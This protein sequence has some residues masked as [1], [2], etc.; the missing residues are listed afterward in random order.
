MCNPSDAI[1]YYC[2][3][4]SWLALFIFV[5]RVG[6]TENNK[7]I[8]ID[9]VVVIVCVKKTDSGIVCELGLPGVI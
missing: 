8:P 3:V 5:A 2:V 1:A 4:S 6:R 7:G 9:T